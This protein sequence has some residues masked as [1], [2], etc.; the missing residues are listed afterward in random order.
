MRSFYRGRDLSRVH[1]IAELAEL[2]RHRLPHFAWEYLSGGAEDE[3]TLARNRVAF[4][5]VQLHSRTLVPCHPPVILRH[6][7]G[8]ELAAPMLIGPTG[9]NGM[10]HR[11]ADL[12]LARAATARGVPFCLSTVSNVSME[13]IKAQVPDVD[14]W[15]QLYAMRD[16]EIQ[17]SLLSRAQESGVDTLLLTSDAMV[18]GNREWDRRNFIRPRELSLGNKL[19]VLRH[20]RWLHQVMWPNGMPS[21]GNLEPYLPPTERNALGSMKFI[22]EQMDTLLDWGMLAR[23]RDQWSGNL[24]LKGVLHPS[25]AERALALG[26]DGVVVSNHGGRQL[27]GALGSLDALRLIA[28]VVKGKM[29]LLLDSG[30]RRGSDIAKAL[31]LGADAVLLGRATLYGVSVAA[32]QGAGRAL[33]LLREELARTLNLMG[34]TDIQDLDSDCLADLHSHSAGR[35]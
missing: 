30:I 20:P 22:G 33:D 15:F 19:D 18:L 14:L 32:E 6:L 1:S 21:M 25:D 17:A 10:L 12:H 4:G 28:P 16:P 13:A 11:D 8:R 23:L 31:A 34:C 27:E 2:A 5:E 26:L 9:Y 24:L 29:A 7:L 35:G 3:L